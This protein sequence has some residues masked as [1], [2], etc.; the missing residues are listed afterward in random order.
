MLSM[1]VFVVVYSVSSSRK[2]MQTQ[3]EHFESTTVTMEHVTENYLEGEQR[4]C[5]VWTHYIESENM[6]IEQA[7]DFISVSHVLQKACAHIIYPDTLEGK[8]TRSNTGVAGVWDVSY[9]NY[10]LLNDLSW[11]NDK[12]GESINISRA[13]DAPGIY[14]SEQS[15]A[16]ANYVTLNNGGSPKKAILLRLLPESELKSKWYVPNEEYAGTELA[17]IEADGDYI[18]RDN[19]YKNSSFFEFYKSYNTTDS[20]EAEALFKNITSK[21]GSFSML[22][23]KK[24]TS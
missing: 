15:I 11:I 19:S 5:D 6:T 24:T 17:I 10:N 14:Y 23:S 18:I 4:V 21:T 9:K 2:A 20:T 7:T 8:S 12:V 22:N 16:F 1:L 13:Y 3:I